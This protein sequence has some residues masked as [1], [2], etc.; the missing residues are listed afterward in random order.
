MHNFN[1]AIPDYI[2]TCLFKGQVPVQDRNIV[3]KPVLNELSLVMHP[4]RQVVIHPGR[5]WV[6][7]TFPKDWWDEV[8]S[9]FILNRVQPTLIGANLDDNKRGTVDVNATGCMDL[10][11]KLSIMESVELLQH[12]SVVLTND[13][14]PLHMAASG[15]AW[16]GFFSTVRH[17]DFTMHWRPTPM[18]ENQFGYK[19][20]DLAK[21]CIYQTTDVS[22]ARNGAKYDVIDQPTL[23][24]WL[25]DPADVVKWALDRLAFASN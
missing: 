25:P 3:L 15:N 13:S 14:A 1:M 12:A 2:A 5:H 9:E 4:K 24:S 21:G 20:Q 19:M 8:I 23:R 22:P 10:R 18:G 11:D 16:I 6:T 7:K 17:P